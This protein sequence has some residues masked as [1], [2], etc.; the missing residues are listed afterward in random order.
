MGKY[1]PLKD[2]AGHLRLYRGE[3]V[4]VTSD[5][6]QLLYGLMERGDETDLNILIDGIIDIIGPEGTLVFPTFNWAFCKGTPYDHFTTPCKTGSLGKLALKRKDFSRTKHP[7]YSF[8][9]WGKGTE[10]LCAI[11]NKSSFGA[12][13]PFTWMMEHDF[14]NLFIDKDLQHSFVFVHYVEENNGPV[15][16]RYLKDFTAEYTDESGETSVR[17]YSMNVRDLDMDVENRI[18]PYEPDFLAAGVM[19]EFKVNDI[20]YKIINLKGAY[21][22]IAEDVRNNFS[23]KLCSY[24][25]Q[26]EVEHI[27]EGREMYALATE[28]FPICRSIM[29]NGV[30]KTFEI[31][32][33]EAPELTLYEV[34]TGTE[35][36][37]WTI[38]KEWNI[39]EAYLEDPE[40]DRI[41][42]F[43]EHN[44][45][46]VGY[47]TPV[48]EVLS[49]EE[50]M[51]HLYSLE[52]QPDVFP[53]VTSYYKERWG[54]SLTH[55]QK[56]S[57]QPGNY[58]AVI[59]SS[60][61][62]GSLTYGEMIF[63]GR[64]SKEVFFSS[65][66]CHPSMGNNECSGQA[67][68]IELAK[69]IRNMKDRRYTYRLV[70]AP[71][72][73]GAITYLSRNLAALKENVIAGFNLTCVGDDRDYSIIHSRY[74]DTYADKVL[75]N[76]LKYKKPDF[77]E[78]P[79]I[80]RGSDERQY[81]A[82]GIDLPFVCFCR[83]KYHIF[84][85]YHTSGDDLRLISPE[86]LAG[87]FD[88]M[89]RCIEAIENNAVYR[90][91]C[92]CEPQLGKRGLVPTMSSKET[93]QET[94]ALKDIL[95]YADGRND[96]IEI[97][98]II[99]QPV[100]AV[101]SVIKKLLEAKLVEKVQSQT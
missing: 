45:H 96:L 53:Y 82:P 81:Q 22:I 11:D 64:S 41:I 84:P 47:S 2:L 44:L 98:N 88:V 36:F 61:T 43:K 16:Y 52:G 42:D 13:S 57:L 21:P 87:S 90:V 79:Y 62:E 8:A 30:R 83:S 24:I 32:K 19:E 93:Y 55:R 95:A 92:L 60:L 59:R 17:T 1:I 66:V 99:E 48:D 56:L 15:P 49:L 54:F 100:S 29:G 35:V 71:E 37:D 58:H 73:I 46:V 85:E 39:E 9:V 34:P 20:E 40:G 68:M 77:S 10:E 63:P 97:S 89:T 26:P 65:Y 70:L 28:I 74:A 3:N 12:D 7:I 80:K 5:V 23:R 69:Y 50:L 33:R 6:K 25:G 86:G 38:P 14:N 27:A 101:T 94:L 31:L 18:Y 51:P 75:M 67:L 78:Y 72:T 91:T 4:F 76:V